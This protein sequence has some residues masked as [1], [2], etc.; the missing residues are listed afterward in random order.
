MVTPRDPEIQAKG[1][2]VGAY[3]RMR[4]CV[5]VCVCVCVCVR[6]FVPVCLVLSLC[7]PLSMC[8]SVYHVCTLCVCL[9]YVF[10]FYW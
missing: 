5:P 1:I 7:L 2:V 3:A 10:Q 6:A 9:V 4:A 8:L